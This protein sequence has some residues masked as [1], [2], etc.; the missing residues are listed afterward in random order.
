MDGSIPSAA[1]AGF[2]QIMPAEM[3]ARR[4]DITYA[5]GGG[6]TISGRTAKQVEA[7]ARSTGGDAG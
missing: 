7:P 6:R 3:L 5:A 4:V 2:Q 1:V